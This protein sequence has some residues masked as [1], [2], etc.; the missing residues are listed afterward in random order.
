MN[1]SRFAATAGRIPADPLEPGEDLVVRRAVD[2]AHQRGVDPALAQ[3]AARRRAARPSRS[4]ASRAAAGS[5]AIGKPGALVQL[6]EQVGL[7]VRRRRE[8]GGR[9]PPGPR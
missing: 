6:D 3:A 1:S 4:A 7:V 5:A 9:G 8:A 2:V